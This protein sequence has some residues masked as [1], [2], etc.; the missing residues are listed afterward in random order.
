MGRCSNVRGRQV[1]PRHAGSHAEHGSAN[2]SAGNKRCDWPA[3]TTAR[4]TAVIELERV[5]FRRALT[6]LAI[7]PVDLGGA[8]RIAACAV[9]MVLLDEAL[10][11]L[12]DGSRIGAGLEPENGECGSAPGH[13]RPI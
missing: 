12:L 1:W 5:D 3:R 4:S 7:G 9:G 8:R 11:G 13:R 2:D 10:V 6:E